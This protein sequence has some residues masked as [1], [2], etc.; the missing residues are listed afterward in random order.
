MYSSF[1]ELYSSQGASPGNTGNMDAAVSLYLCTLGWDKPGE[2][3]SA[4]V[5]CVY[6]A[7]QWSENNHILGNSDKT[8][9]L[10]VDYSR[11]PSSVSNITMQRKGIEC[12]HTTKLL[13]VTITSDLTWGE[14]VDTIHS[15][16]AQR[17]YFQTLLKRTG[18]PLQSM[19]KVFT[20]VR[21][22]LTE[23]AC[24]VWHTALTEQQSGKAG[25]HSATG[26]EDHH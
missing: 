16:A 12:V 14:H 8:K 22:P 1:L 20:A 2:K 10:L 11:E 13:G 18:M 19:L 15:K 25:E 26:L 7:L 9:A 21:R 17:L 3:G 23:Y 6:Q 24:R 5:I 4:E